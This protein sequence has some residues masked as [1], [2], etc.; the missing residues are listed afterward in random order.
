METR[1]THGG[2]VSITFKTATKTQSRLRLALQGPSGSGKTYSALSI[3]KHLATTMDRVAFIDTE[4]GSAS[5]YAGDFPGFQTVEIAHNYNPQHFMDGLKAAAEAG[6]E[7]VVIDSLTHAWNGPGGFL[8]LVD[9]EVKKMQAKGWKADSFAAWKNLTPVYNRLIQSILACPIHVIVCLRAKQEYEKVNENGKVSVKKVGMA[10]EIRENFQYEL[11]IE[12][13]MTMDH[14]F[15]VGKTR[16]SAIDG[17]V[18]HKPGKDLANAL[19]AWLSDG[20]PVPVAKPPTIG[21]SSPEI[22]RPVSLWNDEFKAE[23]GAIRQ[24]IHELG[25]ASQFD[26]LWKLVKNYAPQEAID[27][28]GKL[29]AKLEADHEEGLAKLAEDSGKGASA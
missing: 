14:D 22:A 25:G 1:T 21:G 16:C 18:Y 6:F 29:R 9:E 10:P 13:M 7:V 2:S 27:E 20:A 4:H 15:V 23:A 3:A 8:E 24:A 28:I 12:G 11:D 17:K 19:Q 26:A 5:K